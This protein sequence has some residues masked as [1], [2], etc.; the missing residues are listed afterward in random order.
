MTLEVK[1]P[2]PFEA[3]PR[4]WRWIEPFREKLSN[5]FS[6]KTLAEF[7]QAK[8][9]R[10]DKMRTW[11]VYGDGELGGLIEFE[12]LDPWIGTAHFLLKPEFQ[13]QGL[14]IR[15]ARIAAADIFDHEGIGKLSFQIPSGNMGIGSLL[16]NLGA[17]REGR[18]EGHTLCGG[19][20]TDMLVYGL[21]KEVFQGSQRNAVSV[22]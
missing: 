15:A 18:L 12:K 8:G 22:Q 14:S 7:L 11:A 9:P 3:L 20:P 13:R 17:K 19:K 10:W 1:S 21:S 2:F 4:I 5:D 16:I 6:P